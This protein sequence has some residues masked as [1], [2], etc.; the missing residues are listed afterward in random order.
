VL[1]ATFLY[2][3]FPVGQ[4]KKGQYPS[5]GSAGLHAGVSSKQPGLGVQRGA[6]IV[7]SL[8]VQAVE[9]IQTIGVDGA[10]HMLLSAQSITPS[11]LN[12]PTPGSTFAAQS[13]AVAIQDAPLIDPQEGGAQQI[14]PVAQSEV[15]VTAPS[16]VVPAGQVVLHVAGETQ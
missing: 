9:P 1:S 5:A 7:T 4:D 13:A 16:L 14:S 8:I 6:L 12:E 11:E 2:T 15:S 10:Q 3:V